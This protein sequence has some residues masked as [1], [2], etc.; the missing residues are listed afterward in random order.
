MPKKATPKRLDPKQSFVALSHTREE[1]AEELNSIAQSEGWEN[2]KFTKDDPRLTDEVCQD[3][4]DGVQSAY[5]D[6]DENVDRAYEY[7]KES[8]RCL[9]GI[10]E[11]DEDGDEEDEE[12]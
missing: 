11:E 4:V 5:C 10:P 7:N 9:L 2:P 6:V 8:L 1:I 3:I 12:E